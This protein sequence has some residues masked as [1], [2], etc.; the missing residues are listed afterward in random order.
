MTFINDT[1]GNWT[2][3][4]L[5]AFIQNIV[6]VEPAQ[7]PSALDFQSLTSGDASL[8]QLTINDIINFGPNSQL[9][10]NLQTLTKGNILSSDYWGHVIQ[11]YVTDYEQG[12]S[13]AFQRD[14]RCQTYP[15]SL[16]TNG[17]EINFVNGRLWGQLLYNPIADSNPSIGYRVK[18]AEGGATWSHQGFALYGPVNFGDTVIN[19]IAVTES[20][21]NYFSG[22]G[23]QTR[24]W[25]TAIDTL[26][27][28]FYYVV[29]L[30]K[31]SAMSTIPQITSRQALAVNDGYLDGIWGIQSWGIDSW[32][33]AMP[34][35][36]DL[37][38]NASTLSGVVNTFWAK[39]GNAS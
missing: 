36:L 14:Y 30:T 37:T 28:G 13:F 12:S 27:P 22:T 17:D 5:Q 15:S 26:E 16:F 4:Q 32:S 8:D 11:S 2:P 29:I 38:G 7:I 34:S 31:W 35:S 20:A 3:A 1:I 9:K 25:D 21:G 10:T 33:G 6:S 24:D 18:T 23:Y 19:Q 39:L